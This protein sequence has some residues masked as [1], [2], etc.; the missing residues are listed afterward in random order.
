MSLALL[1]V[2]VVRATARVVGLALLAGGV[3]TAASAAFRWYAKDRI[4]T[5][6]AVLGGLGIVAVYLNTTVAL[7]QVIGGRA[8]LLDLEL[9]LL[10]TATLAVATL[11]TLA[12][13]RLGDRAL[14]EAGVVSGVR[15]VDAEVSRL[16]RT[17]GRVT[18]VTLPEADDIEDIDGY[19]PVPPGTKATLAGKTLI[20]PRNL[21]VEELR[22]RVIARLKEDHGVGHVGLRLDEAGEVSF[23]ALGSRASGI[24]PTLAPGTA[25]TALVADPAYAATSGDAV[26]LWTEDADGAAERVATA[27][28]RASA[29]DVVTVAL[30][31]AEALG[32]DS[33]RRYRLV[34]Q[35]SEARP[36]REFAGLLRSADETMGVIEVEASSPLEGTAIADLEVTV[37]A[38]RADDGSITTVPPRDRR[39]GAG[40]TVYAIDRPEALREVEALAE[41]PEAQPSS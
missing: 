15:E 20:F 5:G 22:G 6:L 36:E 29:G 26:Q 23:L 41:A 27:E 12:G 14:T 28:L 34:T 7:G 17:V 24:G 8:G 11:A 39:L 1:G 9:A 2:D 10:N 19:D 32:L 4:P 33:G 38:V 37:F 31:E 30:D 35:P 25:A 40:D 3:S 18:P 13:R 21:T 16:V